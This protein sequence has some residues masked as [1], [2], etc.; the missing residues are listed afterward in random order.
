MDCIRC[1][2]LDFIYF[3][4]LCD[5]AWS[6]YS[7]KGSFKVKSLTDGKARLKDGKIWSLSFK[8]VSCVA[9]CVCECLQKLPL[10]R[11]S[12]QIF[13]SFTGAL[14]FYPAACKRDMKRFHLNLL[15]FKCA[16]G[17]LVGWRDPLFWEQSAPF[18]FWQ[19]LSH[20]YPSLLA[21][22]VLT[23]LQ[24]WRFVTEKNIQHVV[25]FRSHQ[26][27]LKN[28]LNSFLVSFGFNADLCG[29]LELYQLLRSLCCFSRD[30]LQVISCLCGCGINNHPQRFMHAFV[31][32]KKTSLWNLFYIHSTLFSF[33][34]IVLL[35]SEARAFDSGEF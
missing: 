19:P 13:P 20:L 6:L 33:T 32:G 18:G 15:T 1:D 14:C 3:K 24:L 2:V 12:A 4:S 30:L 35:R 27:I 22:T 7:H 29:R 17:T 5:I 11:I 28:I 31:R 21:Y 10:P 16:L 26:L 34:Q 25:N 23:S 8:R 9:A